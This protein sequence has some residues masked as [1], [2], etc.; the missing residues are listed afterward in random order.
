MT[1]QFHGTEFQL[2]LDAGPGHMLF[3]LK[4]HKLTVIVVQQLYMD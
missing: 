3:R 2:I 4:M 1:E